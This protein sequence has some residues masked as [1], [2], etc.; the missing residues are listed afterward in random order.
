MID[1]RKNENKTVFVRLKEAAKGAL[2]G[3]L[4]TSSAPSPAPAGSLGPRTS[5]T[6]SMTGSAESR[7]ASDG[8]ERPGGGGGGGA[9]VFYFSPVQVPMEKD[10]LTRAR[11]AASTASPRRVDAYK[12][13]P[14]FSQ[15]GVARASSTEV[16]L[17]VCVCV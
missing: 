14:Y 12:F 8:A 5:M 16:C 9:G 4:A 2:G 10:H 3:L 6:G 13:L 1:R 7:T 17:C 11:S 15:H